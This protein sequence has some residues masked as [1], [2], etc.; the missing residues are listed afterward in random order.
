MLTGFHRTALQLPRKSAKARAGTRKSNTT[1]HGRLHCGK[2]RLCW[3]RGER[4]SI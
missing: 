1:A 2:H 3:G 4:Q